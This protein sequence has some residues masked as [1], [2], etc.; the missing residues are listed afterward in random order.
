MGEKANVVDIAICTYRWVAPDGSIETCRHA[1]AC[2]VCHQ[3][4]RLDG[5][6]ELG[7]CTGHLGLMW[8]IPVP[9]QDAVHVRNDL[10]RARAQIRRQQ[11]RKR[12]K[13]KGTRKERRV[14]QAKA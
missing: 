5:D 9:G 14:Q 6:K 8:W 2:Q 7:H 4:S 1:E 12:E 11:E 13:Q 3:C 10:D